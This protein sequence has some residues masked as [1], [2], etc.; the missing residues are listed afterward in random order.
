M[1]KKDKGTMTGEPVTYQ[2]P[3][4][5]GGVQIETFIPWT[6]VKRGVRRQVITPLN[7][8]EQFQGEAAAE[9]RERKAAKDTPLIR[10]LGLAHYWQRLLDDGRFRTITEIAAIEGIDLGQASRIARLAQLAPDIVEACVA[11]EENGLAL[12]HLVRRAF[13]ADWGEQRIE[14]RPVKGMTVFLNSK[15]TNF[16]SKQPAKTWN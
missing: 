13:P 6:L 16:V 3:A 11:G 7:S 12:E 10:A 9:R 8:P 2:I 14:L 15:S 1:A 5:A 4:P